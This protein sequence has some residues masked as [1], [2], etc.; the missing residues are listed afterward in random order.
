MIHDSFGTHATACDELASATRAMFIALYDEDRLRELRDEVVG[1][2]NNSG[3]DQL[4]EEVPPV[5][6]FGSFDIE[7]V[8]E[9]DYFFA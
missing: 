2:L 4:V 5:P 8:R 1:L 6:E 7:S 9:S 3:Y